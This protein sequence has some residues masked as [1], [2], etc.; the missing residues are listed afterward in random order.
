M[1]RVIRVVLVVGS[2]FWIIASL[3]AQ[4]RVD[5]RNMYERCWAVVPLVGKG[6]F[7]D[8]IRPMYAPL[9]SAV[10]ISAAAPRTGILGFTHVLSDDGKHALVEFVARDRSAFNAI[11][12]DPN[13]TA[14]IKGR[15]K[16]EDL[17]AEFLKHKKGFDFTNFGVSIR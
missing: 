13:V 9:P 4:P 2:L 8:P 12:A 7:E 3:S 14:F 15:D 10:K 1:R 6:T 17:E 11:L 16:R 5:P